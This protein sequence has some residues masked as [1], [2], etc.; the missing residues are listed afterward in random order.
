MLTWLACSVE[1]TFYANA[2]IYCSYHERGPNGGIFR[3]T[4]FFIFHP[5]LMQFFT[6]LYIGGPLRK[7]WHFISKTGLIVAQIQKFCIFG[8]YMPVEFLFFIQYFTLKIVKSDKCS[9]F[10]G[11]S[12]LICQAKY[13]VYTCF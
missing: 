4:N 7:C 12:K 11:F 1:L 6:I 13:C 10:N 2:S 5:I 9:K 3:F 8:M